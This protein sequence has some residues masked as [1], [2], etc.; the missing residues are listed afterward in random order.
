[1]EVRSRCFVAVLVLAVPALAQADPIRI[2]SGT[3]IVGRPLIGTERAAVSLVWFNPP[4]AIFGPAAPEFLEQSWQPFE[5]YSSTLLGTTAPVQPLHPGPAPVGGTFS[6]SNV[7]LQ[8]SGG[9]FQVPSVFPP[10]DEEGLYTL[11]R[12][13]S[14]TGHWMIDVPV[15]G[16][17][18]LFDRD[19]I[20][21]GRAR[22]VLGADRRTGDSIISQVI[23]DFEGAAPIPEPATLLLLGA[24]S[25]GLLARRRASAQARAT[26]L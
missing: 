7:S 3:F 24:G 2:M 4:A 17:T 19:I 15:D 11:T 5:E 26:R 16:G 10:T 21:S 1:M 25:A 14:M 20:G 12:P 18:V 22:L 6:A 23:Y 9:T 8:F 13:F